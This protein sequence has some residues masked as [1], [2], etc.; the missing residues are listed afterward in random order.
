MQ[1][2]RDERLLANPHGDIQQRNV[3]IYAIQRLYFQNICRYAYS[4]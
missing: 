2:Q 3:A 1:T 4:T